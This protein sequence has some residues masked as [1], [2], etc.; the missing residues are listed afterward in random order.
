MVFIRSG[1]R[2]GKGKPQVQADNAEVRLADDSVGDLDGGSRLRLV[3]EVRAELGWCLGCHVR[4]GQGGS[5]VSSW[6]F[7]FD[8]SRTVIARPPWSSGT[9]LCRNIA[10]HSLRSWQSCTQRILKLTRRRRNDSI[11]TRCAISPSRAGLKPGCNQKLCKPS[12]AMRRC[13]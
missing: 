11:G 8:W 2:H 6:I 5:T 13:R 10:A 3:S 12:L 1:L 4:C 9:R 7:R